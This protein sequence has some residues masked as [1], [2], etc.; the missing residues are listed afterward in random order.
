MFVIWI[1]V[2]IMG[3]NIE[4][5]QIKDVERREINNWYIVYCFML[6]HATFAPALE[7]T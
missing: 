4:W 7:P 2:E 1:R 3:V 6:G 5:Y